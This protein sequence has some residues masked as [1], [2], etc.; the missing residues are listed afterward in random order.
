MSKG[1]Y[2]GRH[3][4]G[5]ARIFRAVFS[6]ANHAANHA[7]NASLSLWNLH[8][9]NWCQKQLRVYRKIKRAR[10][11]VEHVSRLRKRTT[12]QCVHHRRNPI[13]LPAVSRLAQ[14]ND[15]L[16]SYCPRYFPRAVP[17]NLRVTL[18]HISTLTYQH[19][20]RVCKSIKN[21]QQFFSL[22]N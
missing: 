13:R 2:T 21:G 17:L 3:Y 19:L 14:I 18:L 12:Y 10:Q 20:R 16:T 9:T 15:Q 1:Y 8:P 7:A 4:T 22:D 11:V 5:R 6:A